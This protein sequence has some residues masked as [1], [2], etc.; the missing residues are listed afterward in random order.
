[1]A[2]NN[3]LFCIF[4]LCFF[5]G[6]TYSVPDGNINEYAIRAEVGLFTHNIK[7]QGADYSK[8]FEESFGARVIVGRFFQDKKEYRG[9]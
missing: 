9:T 2:Y 7:V 6:S 3:F 5:T 8:L 1:M 4:F